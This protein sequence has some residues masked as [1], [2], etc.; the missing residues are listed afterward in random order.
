MSA[1]K[2]GYD[3]AMLWRFV[4]W[5]L[6]FLIPTNWFLQLSDS[7]QYLAG[8]RVDYLIPK[9]YPL[10]LLLW[11]IILIALT[12]VTIRNKLCKRLKTISNGWWIVLALGLLSQL[13]SPIP[14][15]VLGWILKLGSIIG[16]RILAQDH[17][18][19][20]LDRTLKQTVLIA[21]QSTVFFQSIVA[22]WQFWLQQN[23]AGYWFFGESNLHHFASIS[24]VVISGREY[25]A[26]YGTTAHP[27]ILAGILA[28][29]LPLLLMLGLQQKNRI[30]NIFTGAAV[31]LGIAALAVTFS[32]SGWLT[33]V[34]CSLVIFWTDKQLV[35]KYT[36]LSGSLLVLSALALVSASLTVQV[37]IL[38][39]SRRLVLA[40]TAFKMWL[41][42]LFFGVGMGHFTVFMEQY[43][44][45]NEVVR[46]LQP[47]HHVGW[48]WAAEAGAWGLSLAWR[49]RKYLTVSF[50]MLL[51]AATLDHY[52]LTQYNALLLLVLLPL[53]LKAFIRPQN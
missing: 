25:I 16:I 42:H 49:T 4:V 36:Q 22:L 24:K 31:L 44:P 34:T 2:I 39:V 37:D 11:G 12:K 5:I 53:L 46:F 29:Y 14:E 19:K 21:L 40:Q 38:S 41:S 50:A 6:I 35:Q 51:P 17:L 33:L 1:E 30:S 7:S 45:S 15:L 3:T 47:V 8:N 13:T 28:V 52:W 20:F 10:E 23:M 27:N 43:A 9:L 26:A 18:P 32:I 48:L